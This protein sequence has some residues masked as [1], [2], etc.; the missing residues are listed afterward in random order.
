MA[1]QRITALY[2]RLS[3][4]DEVQ[5][6]SNS[7]VNQKKYLEDYASA[8]GFTDI[9][10]FTDD[11][12]T[13][14]N[15]NRPGFNDMLDE[16][17][18][19]NV[20]CVIVKDMSRFGRNY[21]QVG[22]Y[23]EMVFPDNNVRF[24]AINNN[25]DSINST[26][27]EFTPFL[28]IMNEWYAR[29]TSK[30]IRAV[31][32]NRMK[33]GLRCSGSVPYGYY[34]KDGDKQNFFVDEKAAEVVRRI[35]RETADGKT[36][37]Q[38]AKGLR[39]DKVMIPAAHAEKYHTNQCRHLN[40]YDPYLWSNTVVHYILNR[41]E[42][43]GHTVLG[44]TVCENFKT[45]KRR[46]ATEEELLFFPDTHE[47]IITQEMW[48][49]AHMMIK[50]KV[51]HEKDGRPKHRLSGMVFCADCGGR[52]SYYSPKS[53]HRKN[54]KVYDCDSGFRCSR[55]KNLIKSCTCH[56]IK[57]SIIEAAI[58]KVFKRVSRHIIEDE[59]A[60]VEQLMHQWE[61]SRGE[62]CVENE[63]ELR[64][65]QKRMSELD[66]LIQSLYESMVIGGLPERQYRK[67]M[68]QYDEEQTALEARIRDLEQEQEEKPDTPKKADIARFI[69][70]IHRY[71]DVDEVS[72]VMLNELIDKIAVHA[73]TGG[74]GRGREQRVDIYFTFI[75]QYLA[76]PT[77]EELREEAE[78][79]AVEEKKARKRKKEAKKR[80]DKKRRI[81]RAD[82][83]ALAMA[84]DEE[85]KAQYEEYLQKNRER[86]RDWARRQKEKRMADDP[87]YA[88]R[89]KER[90]KMQQD[91][92]YAAKVHS[93]IVKARNR[94]RG[95]KRKAY[96]DDLKLRALTDPQ[97]AKELEEYRAYFREAQRRCNER[98]RM[99]AMNG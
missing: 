6:E 56:S 29:D 12:Y 95:D 55:Y 75:G 91:K 48:D 27:N 41:K 87:E 51:V 13:G 79:A 42:Y 77:E 18:A 93:E 10:H 96:R 85:A 26:D 9:R 58:L 52:M 68:K 8:N 64:Q 92:E 59:D 17:K 90:E 5:G 61:Q 67:L 4:D 32:Q 19:G 35:F 81:K 7:I 62:T 66:T 45:K 34:R 21:L 36:S 63:K 94:R 47:A 2:E 20:A 82:L 40:Y 39:E 22:F 46:K 71:T 70:L 89:M 49:A 30:K 99:V 78:K 38:I 74:R 84:G 33:N 11:G 1:K 54:G 3:R 50:R 31:F 65:S 53:T 76:P 14:L 57:A 69:D 98:K 97:A 60:F 73:A 80:A 88:A 23:T 37:S 25:V 83:K 43:L 24:I 16:V 15:F 28:N 72:D 44:K 86:N